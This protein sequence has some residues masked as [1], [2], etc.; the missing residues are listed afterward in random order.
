M[1]YRIEPATPE[2]ADRIAPLIMMAMDED[3]CQHFAGPCHT[4]D[5]F[6]QM[7][8]RLVRRHDSQYS[9]RNTLVART[10]DGDIAGIIT[11]YDGAQLRPLR[12]AFVQ[13]ALEA[14]GRDYSGMDDETQAGEHYIDSLAV[15]PQYRKQ[16]IA[17]ALL[18]EM[19][20]RHGQQQPVGLLVD[21]THPWAERLYLSLG[22]RQVGT[23]TWG[24][25]QMKHLQ[26]PPCTS[27]HEASTSQPD[28][29][30]A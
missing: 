24:G 7:M 20:S 18:R 3:C 26:H 28:T 10:A 13:A 15:H 17:S 25:H 12:R 14:F 9:Y 23:A 5:D 11:A 22:F 16:G 1:E 4:L 21:V 27:T 19:I 30:Q 8:T 2:Q 6:R 29:R